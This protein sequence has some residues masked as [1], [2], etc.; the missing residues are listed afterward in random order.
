[1]RDG[2]YSALSFEDVRIRVGFKAFSRKDY[3]RFEVD[4]V[5]WGA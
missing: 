4:A 2:R 3:V 5:V 1:M